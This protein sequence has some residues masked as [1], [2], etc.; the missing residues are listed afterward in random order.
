MSIKQEN[1]QLRKA[2]AG[3]GNQRLQKQQAQAAEQREREQKAREALLDAATAAGKQ[4]RDPISQMKKAEGGAGYQTRKRG[5]LLEQAIAGKA[6]ETEREQKENG[7]AR[8]G[9]LC[10]LR[11]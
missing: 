10:S 5:T 9:R 4:A 3:N 1:E 7:Q 8:P 11:Y 6:M 2:L